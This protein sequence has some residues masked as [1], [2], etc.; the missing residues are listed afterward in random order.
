MLAKK[1]VYKSELQL[2]KLPDP[3]A[4]GDQ[5]VGRFNGDSY[6]CAQRQQ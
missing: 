5:L 6:Y 4:L 1:S 3:S 2:A